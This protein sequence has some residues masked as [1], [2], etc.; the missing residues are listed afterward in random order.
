[1]VALMNVALDIDD[2][3][4]RHPEFFA[5]LSK[6]LKAAGHNVYVISYRADYDFT[7]IELAEYGI[8]Y[9]ELIL[10]ADLDLDVQGFYKWKAE[11]CDRLKI[12]VFF[13]DM[14]EVANELSDSTV[15]FL[16]FDRDLGR[17]TY[18]Q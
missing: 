10:A 2:T 14:P 13:E 6:A 3:I 4:T 18:H 9:D 16:P 8:V 1:M 5:F 11:M 17:I 7:K 15:C 12:D